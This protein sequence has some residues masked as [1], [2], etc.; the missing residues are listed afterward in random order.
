MTT[1][2]NQVYARFEPE[3]AFEITPVQSSVSER[4]QELEVLKQRLL[5]ESLQE[6]EG[7]ELKPIVRRA[8]NEAAS[9]AWLTP[10]PL[11]VFPTLLEEKRHEAISRARK[12]RKIRESTAKL[13]LENV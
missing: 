8:A 10:Y 3:V 13:V 9:L 6:L 4:D 7:G 2:L 12:Q 11:L 1:E 5:K